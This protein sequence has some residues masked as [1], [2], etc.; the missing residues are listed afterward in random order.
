MPLCSASKGSGSNAPQ[1]HL[2]P[3]VGECLKRVPVQARHILTRSLVHNPAESLLWYGKSSARGPSSIEP[4]EPIIEHFKLQSLES[5][6]RMLMRR[7]FL[8][9]K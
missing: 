1:R 3:W 8:L 7:S 5:F 4:I 6:E 2:L 9:G